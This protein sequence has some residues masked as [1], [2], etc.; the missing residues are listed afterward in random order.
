MSHELSEK[1]AG[2]ASRTN[3]L[4]VL[5]TGTDSRKLMQLQDRLTDLQLA[6]IVKDL[7]SQQADYRAAI[8]GLNEAISYIGDATKEIQDVVKAIQLIAKA[9]KLAE[10]AL[11]SA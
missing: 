11:K 4:A 10:Q 8:N 7:N 9:A 6:A 3:N 2:L 1:I 5:H